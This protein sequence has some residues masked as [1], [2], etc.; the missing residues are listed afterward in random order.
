MGHPMGLG[1]LNLVVYSQHLCDV[2]HLRSTF[3]RTR[4]EV[5]D[6]CCENSNTTVLIRQVNIVITDA[7]RKLLQ[8]FAH[9]RMAE[10]SLLNW[11]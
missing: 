7:R 9:K 3:G 1:H 6:P 4:N 5:Q 10:D 2:T 8:K 11:D